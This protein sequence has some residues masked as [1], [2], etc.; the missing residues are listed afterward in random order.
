M[1]TYLATNKNGRELVSNEEL[2]RYNDGWWS[3]D[4]FGCLED[5]A[6]YL[7]KGTI[8]TLIGVNMTWEDEPIEL[9]EKL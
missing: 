2:F 3:N 1:K 6:V 4:C 9:K 7:P 8:Y 5:S